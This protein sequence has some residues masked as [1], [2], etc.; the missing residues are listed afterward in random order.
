MCAARYVVRIVKFTCVDES[1]YDWSGSDEPYWVFTAT[2][3][4][5]QVFSTRSKVFGDVD[6]GDTRPFARDNNRNVVWPRQR[7]A[8]GGDA[9]IALSIQLRESDQGDPEV[10]LRKTKQAFTIAGLAPGIGSWVRLA[11]SIV[12]DKIARFAGDDLM[13]SKT[14][15]FG[16]S[17][18]ARQLPNVG[19]R[20]IRKDR[21]GGSSG[22]LPWE[23]AGGP[24]YDL[25]T[26]VRRVAG[27]K[28]GSPVPR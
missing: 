15:V 11:P 20:F 10:I 1:G 17:Q 16:G 21:F 28:W 25:F 6:S 13:G 7:A 14:L 9:P 5:H 27:G 18:L 23:V 26:E 2:S 24:D 22:D 4:D 19:D 8:A 3:S 12:Q